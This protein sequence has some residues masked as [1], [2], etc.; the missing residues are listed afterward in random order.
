[1]KIKNRW[2]LL[3]VALIIMSISGGFF[4]YFHVPAFLAPLYAQMNDWIAKHKTHLQNGLAKK[5]EKVKA[6]LA[7]RSEGEQP[8]HFEFYSTLPT[9]Q[10]SVPSMSDAEPKS[11]VVAVANKTSDEIIT[12]SLPVTA[13]A[14]IVNADE[15]EQEVSDHLKQINYFV[16]LGLF[17]NKIAAENYR[18]T[19]A[20]EGFE[21]VVIKTS[22]VDKQFYRVQLGPFA[23]K[24]QA[25]QTQELLKKKGVNAIL[26]SVVEG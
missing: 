18:K 2:R 10:V 17:H 8:I 6:K 7:N 4:F 22:V 26:R 3:S 13:P 1:M 20:D 21:T 16:Q 14:S 24:E 5:V 25:K 11:K 12:S 19:L 23:N 9:M 15:L